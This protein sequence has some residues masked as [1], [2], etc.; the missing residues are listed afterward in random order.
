MKQM[1]INFLEL[2]GITDDI[3]FCT[4]LAKEDSIILLPSRNV[5]IP[6]GYTTCGSLGTQH[7]YGYP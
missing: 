3:E 4:K 5:L 6:A 7:I 1:Q 2:E